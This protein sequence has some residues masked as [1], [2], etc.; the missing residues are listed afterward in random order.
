MQIV[1]TESCSVL[2]R[3][4]P[5]LKP[6]AVLSNLNTEKHMKENA[7]VPLHTGMLCSSVPPSVIF[8][9]DFQWCPVAVSL[10][11]Q[12]PSSSLAQC[13]MHRDTKTKTDGSDARSFCHDRNS[14]EVTCKQP[15]WNSNT[16]LRTARTQQTGLKAKVG[17]EKHT[18][19]ASFPPRATKSLWSASSFTLRKIF[20]KSSS[21]S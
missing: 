10:A 4:I 5:T 12:G 15:P 2:D 16:Q 1:Y 14:E 7:A 9:M 20:L 11:L 6:N 17:H 18:P 21:V 3:N 8:G 13:W 19:C